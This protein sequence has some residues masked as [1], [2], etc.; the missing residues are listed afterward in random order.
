MPA[1]A[2]FVVASLGVTL[3]VWVLAGRAAFG[4][5]WS[6]RSGILWSVSV[7]LGCCPVLALA[8]LLVT[9]GLPDLAYMWRRLV[10]FVG[11]LLPS[12]LLGVLALPLV[13]TLALVTRALA[14]QRRVLA[15][16][17]LWLASVVAGDLALLPV[18]ASLAVG[19]EALVFRV[20]RLLGTP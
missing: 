14:R 15:G 5:G 8:A 19:P 18:V 1:L 16:L 20:L 4:P 11:F 13:V 10:G 12:L 7:G 2:V 17:G 6:L 9:Y 3:V